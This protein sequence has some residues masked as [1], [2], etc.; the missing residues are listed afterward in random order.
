MFVCA[1]DRTMDQPTE[2]CSH[3]LPL[4]H[5]DKPHDMTNVF[6]PFTLTHKISLQYRILS[7]LQLCFY[8]I[9]LSLH[10]WSLTEK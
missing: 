7:K 6:S 3:A 9:K 4:G 2:L 10:I 1:V 5:R 8:V